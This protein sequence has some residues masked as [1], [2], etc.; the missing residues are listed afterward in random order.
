MLELLTGAWVT[1]AIRTAAH[2]RIADHLADGASTI[3]ELAPLTSADPDLLHRLMRYLATLGI[4]RR[5]DDRWT[6]TALGTTLRSDV[7][8]SLRPVALLYGGLFYQ[9]FGAL[10]HALTT[11]GNP[12]RHVFGQAPFEYL[13]DHSDDGRLFQAAMAAG[14]AFFARLPATID[15]S[16]ITTVVDIA[17]GRGELLSQLLAAAPHLKGILFEQSE[18]IDAARSTLQERGIL[19]RCDLV[20]GD[21]TDALPAEGDL[22]VLSR[23]LH[24]W[25]DRMCS[26]ILANCRR[27]MSDDASLLIVERPLPE[28]GSSSL[29]TAWDLQMLVNNTSGRERTR[30]EYRRLLQQE[31]FSFTTEHPLSLDMVALQAI[32]AR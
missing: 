19:H 6:L 30:T 32:P 23:V 15:L 20:A 29:A 28:D 4:L 9:S 16:A 10:P 17:G 2:L 24:D 11:G 26:R 1:Q 25:D 31:G 14:A 3:A 27:A 18:V 7:P 5:H 21:F 22:Y 8:G 13:R 12:F